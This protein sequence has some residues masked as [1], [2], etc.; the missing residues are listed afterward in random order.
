[1]LHKVYNALLMQLDC[2]RDLTFSTWEVKLKDLSLQAL[3]FDYLLVLKIQDLADID[4]S[5]QLYD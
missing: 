5:Y 3:E 1:M 2:V 4:L